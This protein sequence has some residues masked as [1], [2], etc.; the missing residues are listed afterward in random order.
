MKGK[1]ILP[2]LASL[3]LAIIIVYLGSLLPSMPIYFRKPTTEIIQKLSLSENTILYA[4]ELPNSTCYITEA[5]TN[6][7]IDIE[8]DCK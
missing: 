6:G 1:I 5:K 7:Y 2:I 4:I 8:I 3:I